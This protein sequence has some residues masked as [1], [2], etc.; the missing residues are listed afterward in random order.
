[1]DTAAEDACE[2][3]AAEDEVGAADE[4]RVDEPP[5]LVADEPELADPPVPTGAFCRRWSA[6]SIP[7]A[8]ATDKTARNRRTRQGKVRLAYML[9][10]VG[11][12]RC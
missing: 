11:G 8:E 12:G 9:I 2:D 7:A 10:A 5:P 4:L 1:M 3:D 6:P